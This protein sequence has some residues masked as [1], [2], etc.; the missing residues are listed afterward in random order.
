[1]ACQKY[2]NKVGMMCESKGQHTYWQSP[3][4]AFLQFAFCIPVFVVLFLHV[5]LWVCMYIT[6]SIVLCIQQ[7]GFNCDVFPP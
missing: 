1:M 3:I 2:A 6:L 4:P 5:V 7:V